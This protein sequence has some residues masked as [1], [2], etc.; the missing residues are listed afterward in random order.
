[1]NN[2]TFHTISLL[3]VG[4]GLTMAM[5]GLG[6]AVIIPGIDRWSRRFFSAFL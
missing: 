4:S 6:I 5:L 1:M 3:M 2:L